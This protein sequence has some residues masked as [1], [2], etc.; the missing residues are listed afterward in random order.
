MKWTYIIDQRFKAALAMLTVFLIVL[1][2][3]LIDTRHFSTIQKSYTSVYEDR[4]LAENYLFQVSKYL[5]EKNLLAAQDNH[6][7]IIVYDTLRDFINE[8]I[9]K[10]E[11]TQLTLEEEQYFKSLKIGLARL[12]AMENESKT[13]LTSEG[14]KLK[15]DIAEQI[16]FIWA[17]LN[18]LSQIQLMESRKLIQDSDQ[19]VNTHNNIT[20]QLEIVMLIVLGLIILALIFTS[21]STTSMY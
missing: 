20:S 1:A 17:D 4:L 7:A 21:K 15:P 8:I 14:A 9:S 3:N 13:I 16:Q 5:H 6:D 19:I 12:Q 18:A 11:V 10:Y 2:T